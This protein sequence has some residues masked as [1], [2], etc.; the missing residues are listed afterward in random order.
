[1][2]VGK[3]PAKGTI[4]LGEEIMLTYNACASPSAKARLNLFLSISVHTHSNN[5]TKPTTINNYE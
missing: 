2:P 5:T 3:R 4:K 1:M